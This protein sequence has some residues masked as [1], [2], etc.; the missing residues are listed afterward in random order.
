M[1]ITT[2]FNMNLNVHYVVFGNEFELSK[3]ICTLSIR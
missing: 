1:S 2:L 3:F